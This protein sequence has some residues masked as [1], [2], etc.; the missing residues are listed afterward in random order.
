MR[1]E[2]GGGRQDE[3]ES[4]GRVERRG[5]EGGIFTRDT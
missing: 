1:R 2:G 5:G 4:D 3:R